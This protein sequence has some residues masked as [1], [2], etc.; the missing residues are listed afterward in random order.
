MPAAPP[1]VGSPAG[2]LAPVSCRVDSSRPPSRRLQGD[3]ARAVDNSL[4]PDP[5]ASLDAVQNETAVVR[6]QRDKHSKCP[7]HGGD[8]HLLDTANIH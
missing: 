4:N 8:Q 1:K 7:D 5:T 2:R 6:S 3:A